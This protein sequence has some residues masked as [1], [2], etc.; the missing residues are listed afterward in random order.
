MSLYAQAVAAERAA[1]IER[2]MADHAAGIESLRQQLADARRTAEYWK[3]C[4]LAGNEELAECRA[5]LV[6]KDEALTL[7]ALDDCCTDPAPIAQKA[8][9]IQPDDSALKAWLGA[10]VGWTHSCPVL[11]LDGVELYIDSCPH[12]GKPAPKGFK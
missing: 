7:I 2:D 4:H 1:K 9:A 10:P 6:V 12:C 8:L 11:C 5:A 3:A